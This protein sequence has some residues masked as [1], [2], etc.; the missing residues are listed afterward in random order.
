MITIQ[1]DPWRPFLAR[2]NYGAI[3]GWL[4]SIA[5]ASEQAFKGGMGNYPPSSK[6]GAWPNRRTSS[7]HGSVQAVVEG[8]SVTVGSN[9]F[10]SIYLRQG[11]AKMGGRRK[12][13]DDALKEGM[14]NGRL[15]RWVEWS[16]I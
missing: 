4:Q 5:D 7:L 13:S 11:T 15:G 9:M 3:S 16:F 8:Y 12:M 14:Q 2:K 1:F 10:Y 6:P